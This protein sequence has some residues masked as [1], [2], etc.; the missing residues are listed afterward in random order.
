MS[1]I[2]KVVSV[3]KSPVELL[4]HLA[5]LIV[6]VKAAGGVKLEALPADI[7]ALVAELPPIVAACGQLSG[8][9]AEDKLAFVKGLVIGADEL[10]EAVLGK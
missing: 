8:D 1:K 5:K 10:A 6:A 2:D 9:L 3:E 7:A 4:E